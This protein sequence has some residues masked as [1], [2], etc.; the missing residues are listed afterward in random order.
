VD[1]D[2]GSFSAATGSE[3]GAVASITGSTMG[4]GIL[5]LPVVAAPTVRLCLHYPE[6]QIPDLPWRVH[7][8][9]PIHLVT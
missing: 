9:S 6:P 4:A 3:F 7:G 2:H 5:A 1:A 8:G